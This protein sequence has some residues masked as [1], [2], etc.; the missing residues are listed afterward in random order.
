MKKIGITWKAQ[1]RMWVQVA[2]SRRFRPTNA[3]SS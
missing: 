1:V 2:T 3:P